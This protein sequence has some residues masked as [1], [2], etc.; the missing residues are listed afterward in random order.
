MQL[1]LVGQTQIL[2]FLLAFGTDSPVVLVGFVTA[3]VNVFVREK[4][5][6]FVKNIFQE[7]HHRIVTAT[8]DGF[9]GPIGTE[10]HAV[11]IIVAGE[12][13]IGGQN[14]GTV[15][16]HFDF[17]YHINM[18]GGG[19]CHNLANLVFGEV[20][21]IA[22]FL[23]FFGLLGLAPRH[24]AAIYS[25]CTH[26]GEQGIFVNLDAP[27]MV[28]GEVEVELVELVQGH[29]VQVFLHFVDVEE[30]TAN[31]QVAA[32]PFKTGIVGDFDARNS[33]CHRILRVRIGRR[34]LEQC[35]ETVE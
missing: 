25:P 33:Q 14:G 7:D 27:A 30:M 28:V 15:A 35:L 1:L 9:W 24:V 12:L 3:K 6:H 16:G 17:G 31:I 20:A 22:A 8:K 5:H 34:Q 23:A 29:H 18:A 19:V 32:S 21:T 10:G 2:D 13:R 26:L 4:F 11:G